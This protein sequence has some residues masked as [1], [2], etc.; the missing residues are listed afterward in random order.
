MDIISDKGLIPKIYKEFME[1]NST[2]KKGIKVNTDFSKED[3]KMAL[4]VKILIS[5]I[6]REMHVKTTMILS[7]A[8]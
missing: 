4:H 3:M 7:C 1:L 6:I 5:V 2:K 8:S